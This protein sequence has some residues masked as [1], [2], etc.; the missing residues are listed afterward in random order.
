MGP[1]NV[2]RKCVLVRV[3]KKKSA[4]S[5]IPAEVYASAFSPGLST[6]GVKAFSKFDSLQLLSPLT[7]R[8]QIFSIYRSKPLFNIT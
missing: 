7:Y 5:A 4:A 3:L 8:P 6:P 1:E 2:Y